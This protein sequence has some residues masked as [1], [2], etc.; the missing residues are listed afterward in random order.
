MVANNAYKTALFTFVRIQLF[1][2]IVTEFSVLGR[3]TLLYIYHNW[4]TGSEVPSFR[5]TKDRKGCWQ[6]FL[7]L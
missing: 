4:N 3:V 2:N 6:W 5:L 7:P 1:I